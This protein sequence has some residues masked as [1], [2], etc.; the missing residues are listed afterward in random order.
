M[1]GPP[2]GS[3][4][5]AEPYDPT[6]DDL[7]RPEACSH[8]KSVPFSTV[9]NLLEFMEEKRGGKRKG[10]RDAKREYLH[11]FFEGWRANVG[12][13]LY[14][15]IRLL[16]PDK[17][18]RRNTYGVKETVLAKLY[19]KA[20]K[21]D[22][23]RNSSGRRLL[24]WRAPTFSKSRSRW[25]K[26][27]EQKKINVSGDFSLV[28]YEIIKA[29]VTPKKRGELTVDE[30]NEYLDLLA[31]LTPD[32]KHEAIEIFAD[33]LTPTEQK[34]IIRIILKDL[35]ISMRETTV[36]GIFHKDAI[37]YFNVCSDICRVCWTLYDPNYTLPREDNVLK[38]FL[39]FRPML[40]KRNEKNVESI[41]KKM[42]ENSG[43][44]DFIIEEK[45]DGER[46]QMHMRGRE[47]RY[48]SRKDKNYTYLYGKDKTSGS[49]T[50]YMSKAIP[51]NVEEIIL[52][53]EMLVY[54]PE[55]DK[56]LPFG[57]LK[58]AAKSENADL[59]VCFKIFDLLWLKSKSG[60]A[61]NLLTKSLHQRKAA[62]KKLIK[63]T[64]GR[65]EFARETRGRTSKDIKEELQR[66]LEECGEGLVIKN[67]NS[68]YELN[69]RNEDWVKLKPDYMEGFGETLDGMVVGAYHGEGRRGGMY[70]S[71]L[72]AILKDEETATTE[73]PELVTVCKVGSGFSLG[74]FETIMDKTAGKWK[75]YK[76]S[77][78]DWLIAKDEVPDV[79]IHPR[80]S[81]AVTV[82]A[83]E[84]IDNLDGYGAGK[85]L[86]FPRCTNVR[87]DPDIQEIDKLHDFWD[88]A[89]KN[90]NTKRALGDGL[91]GHK[92]KKRRLN[93]GKAKP[94]L[95]AAFRGATGD[96]TA[97]SQ[98]FTGMHFW[99]IRGTKEHNKAALETMILENGGEVI[100]TSKSGGKLVR[101]VCD[102]SGFALIDAQIRKNA[103]DIIRP[104]WILD[105]LSEGKRQ[106]F[107]EYYMLHS[108]DEVKAASEEEVEEETEDDVRLGKRVA[109][110][111]NDEDEK[112]PTDISE[113]RQSLQDNDP[114]GINS[115][116]L[117]DLDDPNN[118]SDDEAPP[119]ES[120]EE[121][122]SEMKWV[123]RRAAV[124][125]DTDDEDGIQV[126]RK[127]H[128]ATAVNED[129]STSPSSS[130]Q[131]SHAV[132]PAVVEEQ[133][134]S[135][136]LPVS[137]SDTAARE[138]EGESEDEDEDIFS[139]FVVYFDT[140]E[141]ATKNGL[142]SAATA[143]SE[144]S[145]RFKRAKKCVEEKG[146]VVITD[147][148]AE[149]LT[150][151]VLSPDDSSR[152]AELVRKT[153]KWVNCYFFTRHD[154]FK[155][156][157]RPKPKRLVV[158][159]WVLDCYNED[160]ILSETKYTP[161]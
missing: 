106:P 135:Q 51:E 29:N 140:K 70:G 121:S 104:A 157:N 134:L 127:R 110:Q 159:K 42:N 13:N 147:L 1:P 18:R 35:K 145:T 103:N 152:R 119:G 88:V 76:K 143:E 17:D 41:V 57:H 61:Q 45:M 80:D 44:K 130:K 81:F 98:L 146:G 71:F 94:T 87:F 23:D 90:Q 113:L 5:P 97:K 69:G 102:S 93:T 37:A 124:D 28:A 109:I 107:E 30:V 148:N 118:L 47:F 116:A 120:D 11:K 4:A 99:V 54:L 14:P 114:F 39:A 53:G 108:V 31:S 156:F 144:T 142:E 65:V 49:L 139:R 32:K 10:K 52:D 48:F 40:C 26:D 123:M 6:D 22:P 112:A 79:W 75:D 78:P 25:N 67:P 95:A 19:C 141:N 8:N 91:D 7:E 117:D 111:Q 89:N 24:Q 96:V 73:D 21:L 27:N 12:M 3:I 43:G 132:A 101:L 105:S 158:V 72:V 15:V 137:S 115:I 56:Y 129:E 16:L 85:C 150:H 74:D 151:V 131:T 50:K 83:A 153:M 154:Q 122:D 59:W 160:T 62:L 34:W 126:Q 46:I 66:I 58:T 63:P 155:L 136:T 36:L 64:R 38:P 161:L 68:A 2:H 92:V 82:K 60:P 149:G 128:S 133:P 138:P 77:K 33:T 125:S 84:I 9:S 100:Q 20:L 55:Q 86:R